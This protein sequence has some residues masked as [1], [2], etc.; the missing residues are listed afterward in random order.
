MR[1]IGYGI[2]QSNWSPY[3]LCDGKS[4]GILTPLEA[5]CCPCAAP[6]FWGS[7]KQDRRWPPSAITGCGTG[8]YFSRSPSKTQDPSWGVAHNFCQASRPCCSMPHSKGC[9]QKCCWWSAGEC[10]KRGEEREWW[11]WR[12]L[13]CQHLEK[14]LVTNVASKIKQH[15]WANRTHFNYNNY[16]KKVYYKF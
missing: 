14:M 8:S 2:Y 1:N 5:S 9:T 16:C 6:S 13:H 15:F 4:L 11:N 12:K 10:E 3:R 7:D